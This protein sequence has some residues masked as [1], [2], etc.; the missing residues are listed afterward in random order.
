MRDLWVVNDTEWVA[1][2]TLAQAVE[3]W[4][5]YMRETVGETDG[6]IAADV[7]VKRLP[8]GKVLTCYMEDAPEGEREVSMAAGAWAAAELEPAVIGSTEI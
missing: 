4:R 5:K 3:T 2:N 7:P 6:D 8:R 1:A